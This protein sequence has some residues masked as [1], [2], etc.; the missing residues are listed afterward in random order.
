MPK[1]RI[2]AEAS[3]EAVP[4][5]INPDGIRSVY[6]NNMEVILSSMDARLTFNEIISERGVMTIERRANIVTPLPHLLAIVQ[7][8]NGAVSQIEE[9]IKA[10]SE[11]TAKK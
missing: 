7:A 10:Q 4:V 3:P 8:L 1:K 6:A 11:I 2:P 5:P 9:K